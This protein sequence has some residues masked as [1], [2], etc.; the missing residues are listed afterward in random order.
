MADEF[1]L[2]T[3][4]SSCHD[5]IQAK[6][7]IRVKHAIYEWI[8][9]RID[10]TYESQI[11]KNNSKIQY[12][13]QWPKRAIYK[14]S[15]IALAINQTHENQ[16]NSKING[17]KIHLIEQSTIKPNAP[18][19]IMLIRKNLEAAKVKELKINVGR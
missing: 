15:K 5:Y 19:N 16:I 9:L 7:N 17:N 6:I 2:V 11:Y 12:Q 14:E 4:W 13:R 1:R 18:I 3:K 8:A 10:Q